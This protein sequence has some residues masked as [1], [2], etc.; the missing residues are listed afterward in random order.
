MFSSSDIDLSSETIVSLSSTKVIIFEIFLFSEK[1]LLNVLL[2]CFII[3]NIAWFKLLRNI[4]RFISYNFLQQFFCFLYL[5]KRFRCPY[6]LIFSLLL[7]LTFLWH[8]L[9]YLFWQISFSEGHAGPAIIRG[10]GGHAP[11]FF[12][13]KRKKGKQ[14]EKKRL[15]KQKLL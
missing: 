11:L 8:T 1:N 3:S 7:S 6:S 5:F 14:R 9:H 2:K 13:S 10:P 4:L 15:S 12:R